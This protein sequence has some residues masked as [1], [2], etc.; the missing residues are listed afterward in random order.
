MKLPR[1]LVSIASFSRYWPLLKLEIFPPPHQPYYL[2]PYTS[3][4]LN[5][6][7]MASSV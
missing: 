7:I 5:V 1:H 6:P 2:L 3:T 4:L